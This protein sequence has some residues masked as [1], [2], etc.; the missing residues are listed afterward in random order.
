MK[1]ILFKLLDFLA[2]RHLA[3]STIQSIGIN[4]KVS[5]RKVF[6]KKH[7]QLDIGEN[8]IIDAS[9]LFD[10]D[11]AKVTVGDRTFIGSSTI[12]CAENIT[13][14][15]DVM[16]SWGCTIIDHDSH[17]V[18]FSKRSKDVQKWIHGSKDWTNVKIAPV[19]ISD[20]AWLGFNVIVLKGITIGEGAVIGAGSV[21][22]KDV[23]PYT[24]N[25]GNPARV[26]REIPRDER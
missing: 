5:F 24:I 15:S 3:K 26:I 16:V 25:V 22:T 14:G 12:I 13:I 17:S 9:V 8:S 20:K 23:P 2:Y 19:K 10:K 6:I 21:V 18:D 4:T 1:S 7:C 11:N